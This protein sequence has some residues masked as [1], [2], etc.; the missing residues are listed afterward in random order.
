MYSRILVPLDGSPTSLAGLDEAIRLARIEESTLRLLHVV[1]E[2]KYAWSFDSLAGCGSD[3][4]PLMQEAGEQILQQGREQA[5]AA[6]VRCETV[7]VTALGGRVCDIV[8]EQAKAWNAGLIVL[9]SHGRGGVGRAL[10]GSDAEQILR[11]APAPVLLVHAPRAGAVAP[12]ASRVAAK[13]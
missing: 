9:G 13:A 4:I 8:I 12:A 2:L 6:A 5:Q 3:L 11:S 1:D 10:L 7:L